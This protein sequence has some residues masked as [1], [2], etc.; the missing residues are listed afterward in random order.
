MD[1][2]A[3][4][5]DEILRDALFKDEEI[6]ANEIPENAIV[7]EGIV[8]KFAFHPG[9]LKSHAEELRDILLEIPEPFHR[10][11]GGGWS[12]LNL[13]NDKQ[14]NQWGEHR[15]MEQL[16]VLAIGMGLG[17]Y[18]FPKNFWNSLPGGVPYVVFDIEASITGDG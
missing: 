3:E 6:S 15:N 16:V 14:G 4:K 13:C 8:Q 7:V 10:G 18:S 1:N 9:R 11:K 5:V 2:I 17:K 12:F